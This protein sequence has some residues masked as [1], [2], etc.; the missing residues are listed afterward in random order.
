MVGKAPGPESWIFPLFGLPFVALGF[1]IMIGRFFVDAKSRERIFYGVTNDRIII[2]SGIFARQIKSLQL[3]TLADVTLSERADRSGSIT[4]GSTNFFG[5]C[6]AG[7]SWPGT[8]RY[9]PPMFDMIE[10]A[11]DVYEIIRAAQSNPSPIAR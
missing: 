4:F 7:N 6:Y 9:S 2:I 3:R 1:Y 5:W 10:S 11:K 8:G